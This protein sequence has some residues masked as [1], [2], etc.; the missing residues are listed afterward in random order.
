MKVLAMAVESTCDD[1]RKYLRFW[2]HLTILGLMVCKY[3]TTIKLH[4]KQHS[5]PSHL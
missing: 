3:I 5:N 1:Q 2:R 4:K